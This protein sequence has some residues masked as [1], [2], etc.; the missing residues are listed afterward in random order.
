MSRVS[1]QMAS[2]R[3]EPRARELWIVDKDRE[4][5]DKLAR[6]LRGELRGP[7]RVLVKPESSLYMRSDAAPDSLILGEGACADSFPGIPC[8]RRGKVSEVLSGQAD[9]CN[10]MHVGEIARRVEKSIESSKRGGI[11]VKPLILL[12]SFERHRRARWLQGFLEAQS[13]AG[14][15]V[16]YVPFLPSYEVSLPLRFSRGPELSS[17]LLLLAAGGKAKA[18]GLGP[19]FEAQQGGYYALRTGGGPEDLVQCGSETRKA[20]F[21]LF[22]DFIRA[23]SEPSVLIAECAQLPFR[24]LQILAGLSDVFVCDK[25]PAE[26]YADRAARGLLDRLLGELPETVRY[27][28]LKLPPGRKAVRV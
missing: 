11:S 24:Q 21:L 14:R 7:F 27:L 25:P 1:G 6:A 13:R 22:R 26:R 9:L 23:K 20:L 8:L 28:E 4:Y 2:P 12:Y 5:A 17:L 10:G 16:F 3:Q 19:C 15:P 18:K